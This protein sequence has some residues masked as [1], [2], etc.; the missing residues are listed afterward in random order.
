M[1]IVVEFAG[2]PGSGKSTVARRL[3]ADLNRHWSGVPAKLE[4]SDPRW[5]R[6]LS[7]TLR[8]ARRRPSDALRHWSFVRASRPG[9]LRA[10][11]LLMSAQRID[12]NSVDHPFVVLTQGP[13]QFV[14]SILFSATTPPITN[15]LLAYLNRAYGEPAIMQRWIV[16]LQCPNSVLEA[17]LRARRDGRS[18]LDS[19]AREVPARAVDAFSQMRTL[20]SRNR[21]N[22]VRMLELDGERSPESL[23]DEIV[24]HIAPWLVPEG[25]G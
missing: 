13:A 4:S 9:F 11:R 23:S 19:G 14:W 8:H 24:T 18:V 20:L 2:L 21:R 16:V 25:Q 10:V 5:S 6:K 1:R 22:D 3:V 15:E 17:R 12:I 7:A